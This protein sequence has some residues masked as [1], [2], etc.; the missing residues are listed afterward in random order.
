[1]FGADESDYPI[2]GSGMCMTTIEI[3]RFWRNENGNAIVAELSAIG[4]RPID[5]AELLALKSN[6]GEAFEGVLGILE[7]SQG[8]NGYFGGIRQFESGA[9]GHATCNEHGEAS[10]PPGWRVGAVK[11]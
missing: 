4:Y 9:G 10:L 5:I 3:F 1:M 2:L 6:A 7:L 8:C 11:L